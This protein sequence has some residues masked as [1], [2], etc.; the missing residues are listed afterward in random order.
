MGMRV[1]VT[2]AGTEQ[3]GAWREGSHDDIGAQTPGL[4]HTPAGQRHREDHNWHC[5]DSALDCTTCR[6]LST[7]P[8]YDVP[9]ATRSRCRRRSVTTFFHAICQASHAP[10][11]STRSSMA[12]AVKSCLCPRSNPTKPRIS[13]FSLAWAAPQDRP[14][15][16]AGWATPATAQPGRLT[17]G[18]GS[19]THPT[20]NGRPE[21]RW[22]TLRLKSPAARTCR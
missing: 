16:S 17:I 2:P 11:D 12:N 10:F 15:K 3:Y 20:R 13:I 22:S 4:F 14:R 5:S 18:R 1:K 6:T 8:G 21:K 9:S 19:A 7:M